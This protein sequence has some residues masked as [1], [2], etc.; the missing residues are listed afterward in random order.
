MRTAELRARAGAYN[1]R[2]TI[3][4]ACIAKGNVA[5]PDISSMTCPEQQYSATMMASVISDLPRSIAGCIQQ[6]RRPHQIAGQLRDLAA[7]AAC[8]V[9]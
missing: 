8:Q 9:A 3:V 2:K 5:S 7:L 1:G 6:F 4:P